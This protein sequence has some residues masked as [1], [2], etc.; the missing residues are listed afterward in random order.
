MKFGVLSSISPVALE[1]VTIRENKR[2][3]DDLNACDLKKNILNYL[4]YSNNKSV[5]KIT[6][7]V[8]DLYVLRKIEHTLEIRIPFYPLTILRY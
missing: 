3:L 7:I 2:I 6:T 5:I 1:L 4:N 8:M